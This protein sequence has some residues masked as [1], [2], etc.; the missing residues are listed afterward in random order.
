VTATDAPRGRIARLRL[1]LDVPFVRNAYSLV[2][3]VGAQSGLGFVFWVVTARLYPVG[4]VG[5]ASTL[6]AT[7]LFLS[8]LS[9]LNLT[10]GFN[11][12]V[13]TA[14]HRARRL[15]GTGYLAAVGTAT[16]ASTVFVI[17]V[18]LWAP[19]LSLL[20]DHWYYGVWF[21][22]GTA[23]W[24]VF[25][26]QDA[27]LT[28]LGEA[29][30]V[31]L[32]NIVYGVVKIGLLFL[33][34]AVMPE[35]GAYAAWTLPLI[36]IIFVI[37]AQIF[38]RHLPER[39]HDPL[40]DVDARAVRRYIGFDMVAAWMMTATIGLLPLITLA[41]LGAKASAY[42]YQSWTIAYTLYL[43]AI[44][45]GMSLVTEASRQPE[46]VVEYARRM[47]ALALRIVAPLAIVIAIGAPLIL[48]IFGPE[49]AN[50]STHLLQL[51]ALSAIPN[52]VTATYLSIARVQRRLRAVIIATGALAVLVLALAI[53]LMPTMGVT[54]VGAA[55]FIGQTLVA[56][57]LLL[58]ELRTVWLPYVRSDRWW[59]RAA[60]REARAPSAR[61]VA[62]EGAALLASSGLDANAW[63][64]V[65][66]RAEPDDVRVAVVR[67][68]GR[69]GEAELWVGEPGR[70]AAA[71]RTNLEGLR[72]ARAVAPPPTLAVLPEVLE[73][74]S[75]ARE[76]SLLS[77]GAG[78]D[79]L[80]LAASGDAAAV[81]RDV[82]ERMNE[83]H[84]ATAVPR[85]LDVDLRELLDLPLTATGTLPTT[86]LRVRAD[87]TSL[88]RLQDE[89]RRE[90]EGA[91]VTAAL[92]HGNLWLGNVRATSEGRVTGL[93]HWERSRLDLPVLD[94]LHLVCTTRAEVERREL[95]AVV[96]DVI[97]GGGLRDDEQALVGMAPGAGE[98]SP[99]TAVLLMWLR[100]VQGYARHFEGSRPSHVW[101]SHNVHQVLESV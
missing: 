52:T 13:P 36:P 76:W 14:G 60:H 53:V 24:T 21:V 40:E 72:A 48:R 100:H 90:L 25:A 41:V 85:R 80:A 27:V 71:V 32:E 19:E 47:I 12:F 7:M 9:Q 61:T 87:E 5:R 17:G 89:L 67:A 43:A 84:R 15:V 1:A 75:G 55:W 77:R 86:R 35:L 65:D 11:R 82:A 34:A 81:Q 37:N 59:A 20:R 30:T 88:A 91:T 93:V 83:L 51:L 45:V 62:S 70:A 57:G 58:G 74:G 50:H 33:A 46:R 95:G 49:Y 22:A 97:A 63:D 101:M 44:A 31:L 8:S 28:G 39:R 99:R 3:S 64:V 2:G 29:R 23:V 68:T 42:L 96:R 10:N 73:A 94:V 38:R 69:S 79:G 26:L 78:V 54:G 98:L 56:A 66:V 92:V 6:V 16:L 4:D 18:D